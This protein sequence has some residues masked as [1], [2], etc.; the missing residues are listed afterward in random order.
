MKL[1]NLLFWIKSFLSLGSIEKML[2][3]LGREMLHD[4]WKIHLI[5]YF[6]VFRYQSIVWAVCTLPNHELGLW[7][8]NLL[9]WIILKEWENYGDKFNGLVRSNSKQE[10]VIC[11]LEDRV[12]WYLYRNGF[13]FSLITLEVDEYIKAMFGVSVSITNNLYLY[14]SKRPKK[15]T[16]N[17]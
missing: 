13:T 8:V 6:K 11:K 5:P 15:A 1:S 3:F 9:S 14:V 12:I 16:G 2:I 10:D 4:M 7:W 17:G